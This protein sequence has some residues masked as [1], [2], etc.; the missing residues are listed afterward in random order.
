MR[1]FWWNDPMS[2]G[3]MLRTAQMED[4]PFGQVAILPSIDVEVALLIGEGAQEISWQTA[5]ILGWPT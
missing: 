2:P 1:V 4:G 3:P 5:R